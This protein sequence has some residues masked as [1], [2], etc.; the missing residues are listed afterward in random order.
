MLIVCSQYLIKID[1]IN[2]LDFFQFI[3]LF[4][5]ILDQMDDIFLIQFQ[6]AGS[7]S[8]MLLLC[9]FLLRIFSKDFA[10]RRKITRFVNSVSYEN[11]DKQ[12][13]YISIYILLSLVVTMIGYIMWFFTIPVAFVTFINMRKKIYIDFWFFLTAIGIK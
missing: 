6:V 2:K 5:I 13:I 11:L 3:M 4:V 1:Y 8:G 10:I 9:V 7:L 12:L